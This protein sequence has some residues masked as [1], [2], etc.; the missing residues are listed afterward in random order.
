[1]SKRTVAVDLGTGS[2]LGKSGSR[3]ANIAF[4]GKCWHFSPRGRAWLFGQLSYR[5]V[6]LY[7]RDARRKNV[8]KEG[9]EA[10]RPA[11]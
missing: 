9:K 5:I 3:E 10:L 7:G 11:S 2:W 8:H 6:P 4:L 1:V